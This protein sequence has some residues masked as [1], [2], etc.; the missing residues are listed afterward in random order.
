[1]QGFLGFPQVQMVAV[2][3]PVASHRE[4]ARRIV[5]DRYHNQDCKDYNDFRDVLARKDIDAVLIGTPTTGTPSSRSRHARAARMSIAR[6]RS[7]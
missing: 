2:C 7:A 4:H 1:M 3:D 6:S 5:N